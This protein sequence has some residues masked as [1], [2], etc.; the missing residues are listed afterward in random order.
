VFTKGFKGYCTEQYDYCFKNL[1]EGEGKSKNAEET[2]KLYEKFFYKKEYAHAS[3]N[4]MIKRV[5]KHL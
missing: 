1:I 2:R 5:K 3:L 4:K